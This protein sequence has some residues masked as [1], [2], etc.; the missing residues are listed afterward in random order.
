VVHLVGD[1][2]RVFCQR[3][4][5]PDLLVGD[6]SSPAGLVVCGLRQEESFQAEARRM[7]EL[8]LAV[9]ASLLLLA[10]LAWPL[11]KL[12]FAGPRERLTAFD[13]RMLVV[14]CL[15]GGAV[16]AAL[17][18]AVH[19]YLAFEAA[20]D[21]QLEKVSKK[22]MRTLHRQVTAARDHLHAVRSKL[23][24]D[25]QWLPVPRA[26]E[27]L[28][29]THYQENGRPF[30]GER[31][32]S[33]PQAECSEPALRDTGCWAQRGDP[34]SVD[35]SDEAFFPRVRAG[36]AAFGVLRSRY[37]SGVHAVVAV[38]V[39]EGDRSR[40]FVT[41]SMPMRALLRPVVQKG[42]GFALV[43]RRGDVLAHSIP[44][45]AKAE[46]IVVAAGND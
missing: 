7:P 15:A 8:W 45:R 26:I 13:V 27:L 3:V 14:S 17:V 11:L 32:E 24:P 38:P 30:D 18:L 1:Q 34:P 36:R 46:N 33:I 42:V 25:E 40:G 2:Y 9:L 5:G 39:H 37:T 28:W 21:A 20:R 16:A 10:M 19:G 4:A 31:W 41:M 12:R 23:G 29:V 43:N 6:R 22:A 35:V 44:E